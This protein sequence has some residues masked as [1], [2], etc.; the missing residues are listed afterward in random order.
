RPLANSCAYVIDA[1]GQRVPVGVP[2]ELWLGGD[3][4]ATGYLNRDD[5]TAQRFVSM[6]FDGA[7]EAE[8]LYR[9]GDR[10][11]RL[12]DGTLEFLGRADDQVKVRGYRVELGEIEL[13]LRAHPGVAQAVVVLADDAMEPRLVA[14]V[15]PRADGYAVSHGD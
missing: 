5:L 3:G 2:G 15:V 13:S 11:R 8:R 7:S 4:V 14:Y 12:P 1:S 6:S 9:T 10:V